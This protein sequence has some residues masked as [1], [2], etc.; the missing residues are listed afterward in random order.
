[1]V[2]LTPRTWPC[3]DC[4]A[5][6]SSSTMAA[7]CWVMESMWATASFTWEMP[8]C[9]SVAAV[10]ISPSTALTRCTAC[11]ASA[12]R[13]PAW[14]A[15][16]APVATRSAD[17]PIRRLMSRADCAV[18]AARVRTSA[19]TTAKPRPASP[20]RAASTAALSARMLV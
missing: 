14:L 1:M 11:S 9:C 5:A 12:M 13:S 18:R 8:I 17:S 3:S 16:V 4:A 6:A 19:A 10:L 20:A 2:S 15:T 7:F